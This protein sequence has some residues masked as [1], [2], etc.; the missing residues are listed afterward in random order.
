MATTIAHRKLRNN[1]S[2]ILRRVEA[3]EAFQVTNHG[4][5]VALLC[6]PGESVAPRIIKAR[7]IGGFD[8]LPKIKASERTQDVLDELRGG[9]TETS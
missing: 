5:V 1:S 9:S 3:G 7:I 2:E 6:P 4:R 8:K